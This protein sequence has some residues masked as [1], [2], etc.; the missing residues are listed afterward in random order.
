MDL[1]VQPALES[2][3]VFAKEHGLSNKMGPRTL[4]A[5]YKRLGIFPGR[6]KLHAS[7]GDFIRIDAETWASI[8]RSTALERVDVT[9]LPARYDA[10]EA[11]DLPGSAPL[12]SS[13]LSLLGGLSSRKSIIESI[14]SDASAPPS[15][16][17]PVK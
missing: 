7:T 14:A 12:G 5:W 9:G 11:N 17:Q 13:V 10:N 3:R 4:G 6:N 8:S 15:D 1:F 2:V 16:R